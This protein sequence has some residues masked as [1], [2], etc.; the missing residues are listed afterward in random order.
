MSARRRAKSTR[1]VRL[2]PANPFD[3]IRLIAE[4]QNDPRKAIAELVQNSLDER[5]LEGRRRLEKTKALD[6][7]L[8]GEDY[9]T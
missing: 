2:R 6:D 3:L 7:A 5:L 9:G 4:S 1:T 8:F